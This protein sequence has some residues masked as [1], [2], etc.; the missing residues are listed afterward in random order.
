MNIVIPTWGL[1]AKHG[2]VRVL[3]EIASGLVRRGHRVRLLTFN[4]EGPTA[5]PTLAEHETIGRSPGGRNLLRDLP[6]QAR[7]RRA[8]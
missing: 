7:M 5:F 4:G 1:H 3:C 8:I 2:G 6:R